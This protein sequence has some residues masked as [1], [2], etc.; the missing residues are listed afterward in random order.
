MPVNFVPEDQREQYGRYST[1][2][3]QGQLDRF[4]HLSSTDREL[5]AG[6]RGPHN[7]LG[8]AVQIGTVRFL[9]VFL[10]DPTDVPD[11]VAA[12]V[13]SQL[14]IS[15][16]RAIGNY[17]R[18]GTNRLHAAEIRAA[19]GYRDFTHEDS[20]A[21]FLGWLRARVQIGA[22]RPSVLFDLATA[23]LLEAKILLPRP[24]TLMRTISQAREE[25]NARVWDELAA[26]PN[27]AQRS[28]LEGLVVVDTGARSSPLDR[29]R[30]AP[31]R[32]SA[33]GLLG[34]LT[35][36]EEIRALG[37]G[38]LD[39]SKIPPSRV[40][41]LARHGVAAKAQTIERMTTKRRIA[42][43]LAAAQQLEIVATD[44]ALDLLDQV[45][46]ALL[47][48]AAKAGKKDR[49]QSQPAM[50]SAASALSKAVQILLDPPEGDVT[51]LWNA[52]IQ[53]VSR[54]DLEAAIATV[55]RIDIQP[56]D[57]HLNDLMSRY[58]SVRRFLP[59]LLRTMDLRS[60]PGGQS[61][62]EAFTALNR[63]EGR[64]TIRV[65]DVPMDLATA[66]WRQRIE[67]ENGVL[68]RRSYT[69]LV[70]EKLREGLRRRDVFAPGSDR[71][72]DPRA[73]LLDG[74][75]WEAARPAIAAGYGHHLDAR[76]QI[77]ALAS[78]LDDAYH[79]VESRIN[80]NPAVRID[81]VDGRAK[82]VLTPLDR[83]EEPDS[84]IAL[85]EAVNA[86]IPH[87]DLP[88][89]ILEVADWTG[90][91]GEF[92]HISEGSTRAKD[93]D[94]SICAVLLAE[95]CNIGLEPVVQPSN[96]ALTRARLSWADQ[97]YIRS[98]TIT[99]ANAHLVQA[100][101]KIPITTAWGG[102]D[103]ASADG[104]RF[105]VPVRTLNAGPNPR[106][107]GAGRGI[108]YLNFLSDQFA[109]FHG[110]VVPG[111][112]RD[113]LYILD[114]LLEQQTGLQPTELMTDTAGYS[115]QV[116]GLFRLNG[117]QFSPR[118]A[119]IGATRFWRINREADYGSLNEL[120]RHRINTDLIA[121]HW[122]DLLRIAGSLATGNVKASELL[123]VLQGGGR[124]TPLG[125]ALAEYGR[126]T[127]TIY[128]LAYL[129]DESYRRRILTQLN[130]TEG[131]H[132]LARNVFHGH[133]GQLRQR[134]REGQEDQLG[135]L[136]LV[137]N[138]IVLW[139]TQYINAAIEQLRSEG[140]PI[141]DEDL[142]RLSPLG[143]DHINLLG[144][145]HF[146]TNDLPKKG[147]RPLRDP[148]TSD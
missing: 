22:E 54:N 2:P 126:I 56:V 11:V 113:S 46:N 63:L 70:L 105:V 12:Y 104:I 47:S 141:N 134:Y 24:S 142:K 58:S 64:H 136:G 62:L 14:G 93:L 17:P 32:V 147:L 138:A 86:L 99:A 140:F 124:P 20:Q 59:T 29:L 49:I 21:A 27:R 81:F 131:R 139:N 28:R 25:S 15:D 103:V 53:Q 123:R 95:A 75:A 82:P 42:T 148:T 52:I 30:R 67:G 119:D 107:F 94:L 48:R 135:A 19:F 31:T 116:F 33:V 57:A 129:N 16:W 120:A 133:R 73:K 117:Y 77:N 35:R 39:V 1:D 83:L 4:F 71:W 130:R 34:A 91:M 110:I 114:G 69:F 125:R 61:A 118:L 132:A 23:W 85:R 111:T 41:A 18:D 44:D 80:D 72:G 40:A 10:P 5:I 37:V 76:E 13:A 127:K 146:S 79:A 87:V 102:G 143:H 98:E 6:R 128:L 8:F 50:D 106:Y 112:L 7:R 45:L 96:P 3:D 145:Y 109:G 144:R 97:N 38:G 115:D 122:D 100:Q 78:E 121:T 66:A 101:S 43:L 89:Q 36:L 51:V 92:T 9:G 137:V 60:A 68:D 108:T 90:C 88:E 74:A 84:L 26:L 65:D 55:A